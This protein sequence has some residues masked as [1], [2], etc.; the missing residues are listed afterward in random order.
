MNR[1]IFLM[2]AQPTFGGGEKHVAD[3]GVRLAARGWSPE[4]ISAGEGELES[5]FRA[6]SIPV[7]RI[8]RPR[9]PQAF[10]RALLTLIRLCRARRPAVLHGHS[11]Y[12]NLMV[13]LAAPVV[14]TPV[15]L[16]WNGLH[17]M[18]AGGALR[19]G[20]YRFSESRLA[21]LADRHIVV[22]R[23]DR[24]ALAQSGLVDPERIRLIPNGVE[25][26][27]SCPSTAPSQRLITVARFHPQKDYRTLLVAL[28]TLREQGHDV[29]LDAYGFG[30]QERE[31]RGWIEEFRLGESVRLLQADH[32]ELLASYGTYG[33][34]VLSTRWEGLPYSVLEAVATGLPVVATR[35]G[36]V[37][38]L[39]I[40]GETGE[41]VAPEDPGE[42]ARMLERVL[43]DRQRYVDGLV[44]RYGEFADA[45]SLESMVTRVEDV[46][47]E[48][49]AE[50]A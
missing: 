17:F 9:S 40:P 23:D 42:L 10:P 34:F 38:E 11:E 45:Y 2:A 18:N 32:A 22:S 1:P 47:R 33:L 41:L 26:A 13:R 43:T 31:I 39:V 29:T 25:F 14:R 4:L 16:T 36:G 21:A 15:V 3:L 7:H 6:R 50:S 46:Y 24:D 30:P 28:R 8:D 12:P 44:R 19:R 35:T 20:L 5:F 37:D 27:A 49:M 48:V